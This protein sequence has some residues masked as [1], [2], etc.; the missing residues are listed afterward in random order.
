MISSLRG[1]GRFLGGRS[2]NPGII[3]E[4]VAFIVILKTHLSDT[5]PFAEVHFV[6]VGLL[7]DLK[8]MMLVKVPGA[9]GIYASHQHIISVSL[10]VVIFEEQ[11]LLFQIEL[12]GD[13][14]PRAQLNSANFKEVAGFFVTGCDRDEYLRS[15]TILTGGEGKFAAVRA[16]GHS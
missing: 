15:L 10:G 1:L 2:L 14:F 9:V 11:L 12:H 6:I 4:A 3:A 16:D 7:C 5:I 8:V 13:G